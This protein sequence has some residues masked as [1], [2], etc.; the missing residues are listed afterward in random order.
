MVEKQLNFGEGFDMSEDQGQRPAKQR[1]TWGRPLLMENDGVDDEDIS[2]TTSSSSSEVLLPGPP[3]R[4]SFRSFVSPA[5]ER[6]FTTHQDSREESEDEETTTSSESSDS[7]DDSTSGEESSDG[8]GEESDSEVLSASQ[9]A[10]TPTPASSLHSRL[11]NLLPQL[12]RANAELE[13]SGDVNSS[14]VDEI[15]DDAEQYIEMDLSLGVLTE[16]GS[17]IEEM[18]ILPSSEG[19]D[20]TRGKEG[21]DEMGERIQGQNSTQMVPTGSARRSATKRKIEELS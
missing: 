8:D 14:R 7:E 5:D 15:S 19:E 18:R 4:Q 10:T 20:H 9:F 13:R 1:K 21:V 3:S 11:Q 16:Q 17:G 6:Q 12:Q 2:S